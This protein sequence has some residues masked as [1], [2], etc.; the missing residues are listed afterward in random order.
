MGKWKAIGCTFE[1]P[2]QSWNTAKHQ[3]AY[4]G[5]RDHTVSGKRKRGSRRAESGHHTLHHWFY[6]YNYGQFFTFWDRM[7]GTW[8]DPEVSEKEDGIPEG[9]LR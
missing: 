9:I 1:S 8:R 2:L 6:H 3:S 4:C 7:M 5:R